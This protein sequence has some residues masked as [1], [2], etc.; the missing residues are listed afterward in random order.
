MPKCHQSPQ[1]ATELK[2]TVKYSS[3]DF[4][5]GW[6]SGK[7]KN[8]E[9]FIYTKT[10]QVKKRTSV[11]SNAKA[12]FLLSKVTEL[13]EPRAGFLFVFS[14]TQEVKEDQTE[15][16]PQVFFSNSQNSW[17]LW[18]SNIPCMRNKFLSNQNNP[19][20]FYFFKWQPTLFFFL[21]ILKYE[22]ILKWTKGFLP[23]EPTGEEGF[24]FQLLPDLEKN[25]YF[26]LTNCRLYFLNIF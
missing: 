24:N 4:Q 8:T 6:K 12:G 11:L 3:M 1:V 20:N 22:K 23:P 13:W 16:P 15:G 7:F 2:T 17:C 21:K 5:L 14:S 9:G 19:R 25:I 18:L 10:K 26:L